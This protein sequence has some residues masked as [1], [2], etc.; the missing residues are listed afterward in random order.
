MMFLAD[1]NLVVY[2]ASGKYPEL[3]AWFV[4]NKVF[5]SAVS[6]VE[7]FGYHKLQP[8][9]K[10]ALE[11]IFSGLTVLYPTPEI[12]EIAIELRQQHAM[13]LEDVIV[14]ATALHHDLTLATRNAKDFAWIK[15]LSTI[16]PIDE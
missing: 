14:A 11:S 3:V 1:S 6:M 12:F 9:E 5:V 15:S 4:D 2:A 13:S 8:Q 10:E 7:T 16:N